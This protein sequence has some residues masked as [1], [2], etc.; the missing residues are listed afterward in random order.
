MIRAIADRDGIVGLVFYNR[1]ILPGWEQEDGKAA[2]SLSH[3]LPHAA[4]IA[5]M[6]GVERLALGTDLDGG[7]GRDVI[8]R[9][10]DSIADLPVFAEVLAG[11]GYTPAAIAGIMGENWLRLLRGV[12]V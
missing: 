6:A 5:R 8:P 2:V 9:E 7:V 1:F 11:A 12:L 4:H 3:L 10:L